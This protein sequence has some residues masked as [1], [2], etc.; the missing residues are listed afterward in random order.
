[1]S[2]DRGDAALSFLG[3]PL[4]AA[5]ERVVVTIEPG[6]S[7]AYD[8]DEWRDAIVVVELGDIDLEC[9]QG[10]RRRFTAGNVLWFD[11]LPVRAV[12]NPGADAAVVVAIRRARRS[13]FS[14]ITMEDS[15]TLTLENDRA[16]TPP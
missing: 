2:D 7:R 4:P 13:A 9:T 14:S 3:R 11:G 5:F 1:M 6:A 15:A 10:G 16:V 12:H 8:E